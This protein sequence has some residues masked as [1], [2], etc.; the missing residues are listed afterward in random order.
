MIAALAILAFVAPAAPAQLRDTIRVDVNQGSRV[1]IEGTSNVRSW[2]CRA[3]TFDARIEMDAGR[4]AATDSATLAEFIRHVSVRVAVRDL[5]CGN[6]R[7]E[8]DLYT[9]LKA[10]D[11]AIASNIV[12]LFDAVPGS[13]SATSLTT[14]GTLS[15]VGIDKDVHSRIDIERLPDGT[16]RARGSLPLLMTDF[17]VKPPTGMFGL[18][19]SGNEVTVKFE[20]LVP[21]RAASAL[22]AHGHR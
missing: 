15:V 16:M 9:A 3:T 21:P 19:R 22:A 11:D 10:T 8:K 5:K 1:W 14:R 7:M 13:A 6:R 12:A 17:G 4:P 20:L 2:S 18:I